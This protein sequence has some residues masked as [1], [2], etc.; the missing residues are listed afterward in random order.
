MKDYITE[1]KN[2]IEPELEKIFEPEFKDLMRN[3]NTWIFAVK[4]LTMMI[5]NN[6][7]VIH[8]T[9]SLLKEKSLEVL[10]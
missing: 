7:I 4:M 5:F 10:L 8:I 1:V 6:C 2:W 9:I 3:S